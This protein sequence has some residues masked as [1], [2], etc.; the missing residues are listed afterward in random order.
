MRSARGSLGAALAACALL[1]CATKPPVAESGP[2]PRVAPAPVPVST[3][4]PTPTPAPA[5]T[6]AW[7]ELS[8]KIRVNR[9]ARIVEVEVVAVLKTG[10][11]EQFVCLAGTREHES[12]FAFDGKAS[13]VHAALLFAGFEPGAPGRWREVADAGNATRIEAVPPQGAALRLEVVLPDGSTRPLD[14]F[15]RPSPMQDADRAAA[16]R[17]PP[18]RFVFGGSRFVRSRQGGADRYLADASGSLVGLVTFGDETIGCADVIPDQASLSEPV[19]EAWTERMPEPGAKVRLRA[20]SGGVDSTQ[21][22]P[23]VAAPDKG[24][25]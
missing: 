14:W 12:L 13:D 23:A 10:F 3:P 21:A 20:S 17:Q 2:S 6:P 1:G 5:P 22:R 25:R 4:A 11:L 16:G 19:W 15:V 9:A 8:P 24:G 18:G 7:V